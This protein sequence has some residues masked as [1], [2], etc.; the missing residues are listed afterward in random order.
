MQFSGLFNFIKKNHFIIQIK[1]IFVKNFNLISGFIGT[2]F[3]NY[4]IFKL[5]KI[6]N[7]DKYQ[8][9]LKNSKNVIKK[10]FLLN[11]ILIKY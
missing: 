6:V 7:I 9:L 10:I 2:N 3:I 5:K 4:L 1:L 8:F 11:I